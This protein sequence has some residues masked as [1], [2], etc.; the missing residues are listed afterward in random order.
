MKRN[1]TNTFHIALIDWYRRE[2]RDLPWRKTRDPYRVLLSEVLTQQTRIEQAVPYY[3][4][5]LSAFP[6]LESLSR[7]S[8][9]KV[10]QLWAG[11]GYYARARNLH[12]LAQ[13]IGPNRLPQTY[14]DLIRLPGLGPYT[15]AAIASIAFSES[16]A[17]VD[18]NVRR[19]L[20]R[21]FAIESPNRQWL[22]EKAQNILED[23]QKHRKNC[24][25]HCSDRCSNPSNR[26]SSNRNPGE[27][28]VEMDVDELLSR[29]HR[30]SRG[31]RN[32]GVL[33]VDELLGDEDKIRK[34]RTNTN[35]KVGNDKKKNAQRTQRE[36][37]VKEIFPG[38]KTVEVQFDS[39]DWEEIDPGEWNQAM[40]ELGARVCLPRRPKCS[41]CPLR[42]FC[43]GRATPERFPI[44]RRT[45]QKPVSAVALV[46]QAKNGKVFL[47]KREGRTLGGLWGFPM[48]E[49]PDALSILKKKYRF[50]HTKQ[51]G[52]ILHSFTHK[53]ITL[54]VVWAP[55]RRKVYNPKT[56]PL[57]RLDCKVLELLRET[58]R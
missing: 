8:L 46:L 40:M 15:A 24:D 22:Q 1:K 51:I 30:N 21:L 48:A 14:T 52:T 36:A 44:G 19:V 12:R 56:M 26:N 2:K 35:E 33:D 11:A 53:K 32:S 45:V 38:K 9:E 6:D 16:V 31:N 54:E 5:F 37:R 18:G 7:A 39:S 29:G 23:S 47:T 27:M 49:G 28:D 57:S 25:R 50:K 58:R 4:R 10:M 34:G 20:S 42:K 41:I 43:R 55:T 13:Q 3:E 17:A